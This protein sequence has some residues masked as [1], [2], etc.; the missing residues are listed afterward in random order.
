MTTSAARADQRTK[1]FGTWKIVSNVTEDKTTG[2]RHHPY[3]EHPNGYA[4]FTPEGRLIVLFT[5]EGNAAARTDEERSRLLKSM[6]AY[7]GIYRLEGDRFIT[8]V[9]V[10]WNKWWNGTEHARN[11][12]V[13]DDRL[14]IV[15]AW[16]PA[17]PKLGSPLRRGIMV[18]E[19]AT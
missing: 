7:S 2:A 9:D 8:N 5:T 13:E 16:E 17:S 15:T 18:W 19:R 11:F 6:V 14:E 4:V 10:S 3:G 1:L 12:K